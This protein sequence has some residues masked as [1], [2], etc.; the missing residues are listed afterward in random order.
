M[1]VSISIVSYNTY[2]RLSETLRAIFASSNS[3]SFE[4]IVVDNASGDGT[5]DR[6][7][8]DFPQIQLIANSE[9][10]Y[11]SPAHNQAS[12]VAR[13][14][15]LLI[16]NS[17]ITV[18]DNT[19][20]EMVYFL[21]C[22]S[23]VGAISPLLCDKDGV[24]Q[25]TSWLYPSAL[26]F[27]LTRNPQMYVFGN[28]DSF[29]RRKMGKVQLKVPTEVEIVCDACIMIRRDL[30]LQIGGYDERMLMY[31]TEDDICR[32]IREAHYKVYILPQLKV[33]HIGKYTTRKSSWEENNKILI[34]DTIAYFR[35]YHNFGSVLL[36]ASSMYLE[37][38][39]S[40]A[41]KRIKKRLS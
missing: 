18:A 22:H 41:W 23:D 14:K 34:K 8:R 37:Y 32:R 21:E 26:D 24:P 13:G 16:L 30:F 7:R 25:F 28:F 35:K 31:S 11:F 2:D 33:T 6:V 36:V 38:F 10:W 12:L 20:S 5:P 3:V 1:D 4:V 29:R 27:V 9:N 15:Y 39:L 19:L 17:D 40:I